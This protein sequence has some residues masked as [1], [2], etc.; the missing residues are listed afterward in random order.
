L[1]QRRF[2][3]PD[4]HRPLPADLLQSEVNQ[5]VDRIVIREG[6]TAF[7]DLSQAEIERLDYVGRIDHSTDLRRQLEHRFDSRPVR[8]PRTRDDWVLLVPLDLEF[9]Q[10]LQGFGLGRRLVDG[11]EVGGNGLA[12]FVTDEVQTDP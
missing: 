8:S 12:F 11:L 7:D 4:R 6:A 10:R 2:P 3:V 5:P 1:L 9:L